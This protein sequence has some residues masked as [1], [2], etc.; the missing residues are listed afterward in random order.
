MT[1]DELLTK[2]R[3]FR[4]NLKYEDNLQS[5]KQSREKELDNISSHREILM[6]DI[7]NLEQKLSDDE[8]YI[9]FTYIKNQSKIY[10]LQ[11]KLDKIMEEKAQNEADISYN[12]YR[13]GLIHGEI[14]AGNSLLSEAQKELEEYGKEFR[15]LGTNPN[16]EDDNRIKQ[17]M[18]KVRKDIDWLMKELDSLNQELDELSQHNR[19]LDKNATRLISNENRYQKLLDNVKE[20]D[21]IDAKDNIDHVKKDEDQ[22][23][24]LKLQSIVDS[25]NNREKY[26]SFDLPLELDELIT[27]IEEDKITNDGVLN[28]LK[29]IRYDLPVSISKNYSNIDDEIAENHRLQADVLMEKTALEQK[30]SDEQNYHPSIFA[31]EVMQQE[32]LDLNNMIAKYDSDIKNYD[33]TLIIYDNTKKSIEL[34]INR[35]ESKKKDLEQKLSDL[36]LQI[37][38]LPNDVYEQRKSDIEKEKKKIEKEIDG[39]DKQIDK[40]RKTSLSIDLTG[41][42]LKKDKKNIESLKNNA[43]K[44]LEARK[45]EI[46]EKASVNRFAMAEDQQ[47]LYSLNAQLDML[48][49]RERAIDY[50][51]EV[52]LDDLIIKLGKEKEN[53][54]SSLSPKEKQSTIVSS[55]SIDEDL[56]NQKM[57]QLP[58]N[59]QI[60]NNT[61]KSDELK[62]G[63]TN[64][65]LVP[66]T[67]NLPISIDD[68][69][70]IP[71]VGWKKASSK[72]LNLAKKH[73]KKIAVAILAVLIA[74]IAKA[75][76]KE[77]QYNP[78]DTSSISSTMEESDLPDISV[79]IDDLNP[80]TDISEPGQ[81]QDQDQ[82]QDQEPEPD[83]D[84][85]QDQE[86]DQDQDQD[87]EP[88]Q[89]Q[90]QDQE[91]GQDQDQDQEPEPEKIVTQEVAPGEVGIVQ[92]D[93]TNVAVT[94]NVKPIEGETDS[95]QQQIA[96]ELLDN[97]KENNVGN[98]DYTEDPNLTSSS[99]SDD[100]TI[101][102]TYEDTTNDS[103][104][105][106]NDAVDDYVEKHYGENS[107]ALRDALKELND[108]AREE[109]GGKTK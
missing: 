49:A 30:L 97:L 28:K 87:Q 99:V 55:I 43:I 61:E 90:D 44:D 38:V 100:G 77:G 16:P 91:P 82:D 15:N 12:N 109:L 98:T 76:N 93:D 5:E 107:D 50:D 72:L 11:T 9:S 37:V 101:T 35:E 95:I 85:D 73:W 17:K 6:N 103:E 66:A 10:D 18:D 59:D 25:F 78:V 29:Q 8:N 3:E 4:E 96:Q 92:T 80:G 1:K 22:R 13:I 108:L 52:N 65:S 56:K 2:L 39:I 67:D 21:Q 89:D 88:D 62:E 53:N 105:T 54:N 48:K 71:I 33:V 81:D 36:K 47:K 7:R 14:E 58:L 70:P 31:I 26:L 75:C 19:D 60:D 27:N 94:D 74:L 84:Q 69:K 63:Q 104:Y 40:L 57:D 83:Q 23:K 20:R 42:L 46:N 64:R 45:K 24:L 102:N 106:V 41:T 34:D 86:P 51:Y 68:G 79:D 32:I